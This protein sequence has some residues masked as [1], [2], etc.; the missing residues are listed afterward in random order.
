MR[1]YQHI[2]LATDLEPNCIEIG[3]R[4]VQMAEEC[5]ARLTIL[6]A[7]EVVPVDIGNE[8]ILPQ[9]QEIEQQLKEQSQRKLAH[10]ATELGVTDAALVVANGPTKYEITTYATENAV[11]LIVLGKHGRRGLARLLGSTANGVLNHAPCDILVVHIPVAF[12]I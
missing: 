4:A 6:H 3:Q 11:D 7:I 8:L 10:L 5:G 1:K 9:V 2:L 12:Q